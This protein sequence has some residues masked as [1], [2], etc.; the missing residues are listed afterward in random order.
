MTAGGLC[1]IPKQERHIRKKSINNSNNNE[2][3]INKIKK[4]LL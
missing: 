4:K 1:Q 3:E 2:I